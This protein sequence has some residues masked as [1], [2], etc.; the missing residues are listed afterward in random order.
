M[1]YIKNRNIVKPVFPLGCGYQVIL[2]PCN[3]L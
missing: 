1:Y 2:S 3:S